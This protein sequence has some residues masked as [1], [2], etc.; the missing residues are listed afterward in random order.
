MSDI[1]PTTSS[2]GSV[3]L[4]V[5]RLAPAVGFGLGTLEGNEDGAIKVDGVVEGDTDCVGRKLSEGEGEPEGAELD[6]GTGVRGSDG[7]AEGSNVV[8][9]RDD[10]TGG[11]LGN[12]EVVDVL[13]FRES[14][15]VTL[16][17]REGPLG[18]DESSSIPCIVGMGEFVFPVGVSDSMAL[19]GSIER[20][21]KLGTRDKVGGW[22]GSS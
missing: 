14:A 20:G 17:V 18:I 16:G 2:N 12:A 6:D 19:P 3:T 22:R 4:A 8:V 1:V 13:G 9:G 21:D 7:I 10:A 5:W 11:L 15:S